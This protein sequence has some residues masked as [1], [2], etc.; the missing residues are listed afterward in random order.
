L[1]RIGADAQA[2]AGSDSVRVTPARPG[3]PEPFRRG[4]LAGEELTVPD[5]LEHWHRLRLAALDVAIDPALDWSL[6]GDDESR[7]LILGT[8]ID[9][10]SGEAD[11]ATM[12]RRL[13]AAARHGIDRLVHDAAYLAGRFLLIAAAGDELTVIPDASASLAANWALHDGRLTMSS[14]RSLLAEVVG[15]DTDR[16][17]LELIEGALRTSPYVVYAPGVRFLERGARP[18]LPNHLLRRTAAGAHHERFY[19]FPDTQLGSDGFD[20]FQH[21]FTEHVRLISERP[22]GVSLTGG[23]DSSSTI[24]ALLRNRR[25]QVSTWT[26]VFADPVNEDEAADAADAR[27]T[28]A[29]AGYPHRVLSLPGLESPAFARAFSR[30]FP[31]YPQY[32]SLA[33]ATEAL[34][35]NA[36]TLQSMIAE[37]GTGFYQVRDRSDAGPDALAATFTRQPMGRSDYAIEAFDEFISYAEFT[38]ERFGPWSRYDLQYWEH[39]VGLWAVLRVQELE[40]THRVELPF[41]SRHILE[42][43]ASAP[44]PVRREKRYLRSYRGY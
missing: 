4:W 36:I 16:E 21:H 8:A 19:P 31:L 23:V 41:N 17:L 20:R 26:G 38:P 10:E 30:T 37:V 22:V 25:R 28:A 6:G 35:E 43:L 18:V 3:P 34:G 44:W 9:T 39:R 14:H 42:G 2:F 24:A 13:T 32:R 40:V 12:T 7:L 27:V 11:P 15:L 33:S 5:G 29:R 1:R